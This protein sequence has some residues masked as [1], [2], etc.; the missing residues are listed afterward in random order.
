MFQS[1]SSADSVL[2]P[3][4]LHYIIDS[5]VVYS[6]IYDYMYT[7]EL[8]MFQSCSSADSVLVPCRLHY[9]IDSR[10]VYSTIYDYM[11][12]TERLVLMQTRSMLVVLQQIQRRIRWILDLVSIKIAICCTETFST[13]LL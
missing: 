11:Y 1:C 4:R 12:T 7:S 8:C 9:I 3:C 13:P 2:V 5:R 6:T 10:V